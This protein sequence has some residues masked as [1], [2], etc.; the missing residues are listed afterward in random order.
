MPRVVA[1]RRRTGQAPDY[2]SCAVETSRVGV[3]LDEG[4][5]APADFGCSRGPGKGMNGGRNIQTSFF[6]EKWNVLVPV[7]S[8][9]YCVG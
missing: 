5:H 1:K 8:G 6:L 3:A 2:V 9:L 4:P 7:A